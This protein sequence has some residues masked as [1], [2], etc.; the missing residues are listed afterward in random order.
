MSKRE[1]IVLSDHELASVQEATSTLPAHALRFV[2]SPTGRDDQF[3][4][5]LF[6]TARQ[7][8]GVSADKIDI[9]SG[10]INPLP[11]KPSLTVSAGSP[12]NIHYLALPSGPELK[13][14]LDMLSWVADVEPPPQLAC[15]DSAQTMTQSSE[16]LVLMAAACPHCPRAVR[17]ILAMAS[18]QPMLATLIVD[19]TVFTDLADQFR[20][21]ST[22]T[23]IINRQATLV[24]QLDEN[25]LIRHLTGT[26]ATFTD[27]IRSMIKS[28]RAE[29]AGALICQERDPGSVLPIYQS[30]E[31]STRVGALVAM[32]EALDRDPRSLDAIVPDLVELLGHEEAA[33][34]GDTAE[35]LG[36][37]GHGDA[38]PALRRAA[39]EDPDPDVREAAED[40]LNSIG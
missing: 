30:Q 38:G 24:G 28:G 18:K 29:D 23:V 12:G 39:E 37:I 21:K 20:V 19:A 25:A 26:H 15:V 40:A 7:I 11:G 8:A 3:E 13:P 14:F 27:K 22:P 33:L 16:L 1:G 5:T 2:L 10:S 34:R 36:K 32:E 4:H 17:T 9:E 6:N 31:F 35:L